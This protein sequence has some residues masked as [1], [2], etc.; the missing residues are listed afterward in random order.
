MLMLEIIHCIWCVHILY[1]AGCVEKEY[2]QE[3]IF[4]EDT[5]LYPIAI[6]K[7]NK[8]EYVVIDSRGWPCKFR[9]DSVTIDKTTSDERIC[10]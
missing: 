2:I 5:Q 8:S 10:R 1:L 7:E 3:R 4:K 6:S 9:V